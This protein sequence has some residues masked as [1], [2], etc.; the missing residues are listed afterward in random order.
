MLLR[1]NSP[2][3]AVREV[4]ITVTVTSGAPY[5]LRGDANQDGSVDIA[6]AVSVFMYLFR[7]GSVPCV[8]ALDNDGNGRVQIS[9]GVYLLMYIFQDGTPPPPPFPECGAAHGVP[10]ELSCDR[11][12]CRPR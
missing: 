10:P 5:F 8:A 3:Q 11:E 12:A 7:D 1:T 4:P 2:R 9:D 6:D